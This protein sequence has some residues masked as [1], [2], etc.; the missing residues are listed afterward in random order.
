MMT[1]YRKKPIVVDAFQWTGDENQ[2]EDPEWIIDAIKAGVVKIAKMNDQNII[3]SIK[4]LEGVM[5]AHPGDYIIRGAA[6]EIYPCKADIFV[7]TYESV[8]GPWGETEGIDYQCMF[9][10][11]HDI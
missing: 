2:T 11:K 3:I 9:H 7:E 5:A 8:Q 1:K 6:G 4:T 10:R